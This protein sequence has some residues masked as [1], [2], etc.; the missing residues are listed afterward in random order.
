[1]FDMDEFDRL[2]WKHDRFIRSIYI[3]VELD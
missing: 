1:M 2:K 3:F